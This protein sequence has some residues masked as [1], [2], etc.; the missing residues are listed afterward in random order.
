MKNV[1]EIK[2]TI[3]SLRKEG[4]FVFVTSSFQTHSIPL[5]HIISEIDRSIPVYYLNTVYLFPDT[6]AFKDRLSN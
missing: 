3:L 2:A 1:K 4:K 5:L 6:I